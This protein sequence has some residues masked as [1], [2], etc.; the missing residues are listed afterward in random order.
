M[1]DTGFTLNAPEQIAM[2]RLL[3]MRSALKLEIKTGMRMRGNGWFNAAKALT[4]KKTRQA[5]LEAVEKII[6]EGR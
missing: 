5:C 4:G 1:Q 6:E 2:Y 3:T